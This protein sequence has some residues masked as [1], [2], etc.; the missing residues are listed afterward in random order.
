M[1]LRFP[2]L[3]LSLVI[4]LPGCRSDEPAAE[5]GSGGSVSTDGL[6]RDEQLGQLYILVL[7]NQREDA[8]KLIRDGVQPDLH[9]HILLG[10]VAEVEALLKNG[11]DPDAAT[12]MSD[13]SPLHSACLAGQP[14][15][16]ELLLK[17]KAN[18]ES[19]NRERKTPIF[20]AVHPIFVITDGHVECVRSLLK[21]GASVRLLSKGADASVAPEYSAAATLAATQ[22]TPSVALL[23]AM[24]ERGAKLD[25]RT[26]NGATLLHLLPRP[27]YRGPFADRMQ[28]AQLEVAE[29]LVVNG[30]P[31]DHADMRG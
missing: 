15:I 23:K 1:N 29:Y 26:E 24:V 10:H 4:L 16:V 3:L 31:V 18:S 27:H 6:S 30:V 20:K 9:A 19:N 13:G 12:P 17:Y 5:N 14:R 11:A 25:F 22:N 28:K 2:H 8:E 21:H 7:Q